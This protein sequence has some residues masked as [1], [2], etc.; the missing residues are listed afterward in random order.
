MP[1][2]KHRLVTAENRKWWTLAA[3]GFGLLMTPQGGD[4]HVGT[5]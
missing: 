5:A 2:A 4:P 3:V 1:A